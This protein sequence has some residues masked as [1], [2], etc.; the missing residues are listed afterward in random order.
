[1]TESRNWEATSCH[2]QKV[3]AGRASLGWTSEWLR[4]KRERGAC[5]MK[6]GRTGNVKAVRNNVV[7]VACAATGRHGD[8][9]AWAATKGHIGSMAL[10]QQ[11]FVLMSWPM[12]P[13]TWSFRHPWSGPRWCPKAGPTTCQGSGGE[14]A[15]VVWVRESWPQWLQHRRVS[16]TPHQLQQAGE[17][18]HPSPGQSGRAGPGGVEQESWRGDHQSYHSTPDP[19][20]WVGSPQHQSHLWSTLAC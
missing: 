11:G 12:L 18:A 20:S 4:D 14:L 17:L 16:P 15:L 6:R 7:W 3:Q 10:Q 9:P 8:I 5:T 1:V 13:P 2:C 19:G